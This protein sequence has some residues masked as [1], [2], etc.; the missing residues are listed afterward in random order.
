MAKINVIGGGLSGVEAAHYLANKG[1]EVHLFEKRP[2]TMTP[3]HQTGYFAELVC[4][5]SLKSNRLD[6]ACGLL[7][8]EMRIMGSLTMQI[9]AETSVPSGNALSVDR[10]LFAKGVSAKILQN[11]HIF[12]HYEDVSH[13]PDE[14]TIIATGPLS[15]DGLIAELSKTIGDEAMFFYDA[16][17]PII[18]HDS[19]DLDVAYY[20]SRYEQGDDSYLNCPMTKDEYYRFVDELVSAKTIRLH[21]FETQF[22]EGCLPVEIIAKRGRDTLRYG[23]LKPKGLALDRSNPPYAVIQLRQDNLVGSL[24]NIVGFQTNLTFSEQER[25]FRMIPGLQ[26]AEFVRYG[27]MHRNTYINSPKV[28]NS[29]LTL[30]NKPN[31][32]I[33]GQL[34][35]VEGY[36]ESAAS[37]IIAGI[38]AHQLAS[39]KSVSLPP[40]TTIIGSL[41]RYIT[42]ANP[43][44]FTPMNANFGILENTDKRHRE[45][46][47]KRALETI[48]KYWE[49]DNE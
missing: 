22:F 32:I 18:T 15:S 23:P 9:A 11:D 38:I 24:Y 48:R 26:K 44:G 43:I 45:E 49:D 17:A 27:L 16:S 2:T 25:V 4:S 30:K 42:K 13:L 47:I 31:I 3:A 5:N 33:A 19:I 41:I 46:D 12:I 1:H 28:L 37:G 8:E 39:G 40:T 6:N 35:G 36:V 7:K 29:D 21:D 14:L 10:D 20:K 34:S